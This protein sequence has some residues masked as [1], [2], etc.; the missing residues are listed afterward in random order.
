MCKKSL[1]IVITSLGKTLHFLAFFKYVLHKALFKTRIT[2][3]YIYIYI[4]IV[5][6][7]VCVC[8][9]F[10][11]K[12]FSDL[13]SR[14]VLPSV[15]CLIACDRESLTVRRPWGEMSLYVLSRYNVTVSHSPI[16][17]WTDFVE[18]NITAPYSNDFFLKTQSV[19][20]PYVKMPSSTVTVAVS[21]VTRTPVSRLRY[22]VG[23]LPPASV[24]S[25]YTPKMK[26][27]LSFR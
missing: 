3:I 20:C 17:F 25:K 18:F 2:Y 13:S 26:V 1:P 14:G 22:W 15:V 12:P 27:V 23:I 16:V 5:C 10:P 7:C 24:V 6:V 21:R 11:Y 4:Y 9:F 8:V 19:F